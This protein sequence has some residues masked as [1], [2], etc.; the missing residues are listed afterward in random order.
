MHEFAI[1]FFFLHLVKLKCFRMKKR[2]EQKLVVMAISLFLVFN[3]PFLLVFNLDGEVFGFPAFYFS[4]FF[5]W[6]LSI[7][8]SYIIL[9]KHYE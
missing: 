8:I 7:V 1:L 5:I 6:L 4:L 9:S 2:H 3:I